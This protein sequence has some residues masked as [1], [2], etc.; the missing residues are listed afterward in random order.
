MNNTLDYFDAL[1]QINT[2]QSAK[3]SYTKK[4]STESDEIY[5]KYDDLKRELIKKCNE[6]KAVVEKKKETF[7]K[8][9]NSKS[10][11]YR[12]IVRNTKDMFKLFEILLSEPSEIVFENWGDRDPVNIIHIPVDNGYIK[13]YIYITPNKKPKNRFSLHLRIKSIFRFKFEEFN[14]NNVLKAL[15]TEKEL[16]TWYERNKN[17]LKWKYPCEPPPGIGLKWESGLSDTLTSHTCLEQ[18]YE[19][20]KTLWKD[21]KWQ[22]A[23][24]LHKKD[25]Y[26]NHYSNGVDTDEY[27]DICLLLETEKKTD[28]PLL[29]GQIKSSIGLKELERRFKE[30]G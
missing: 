17:E 13:V 22:R 20:T 15:P 28:L 29:I 27:H 24:W 2:L 10:E 4:C 23:Y 3:E 14:I 11:P 21:K 1:K 12:Q 30:K 19:E 9:N 8:E 7:E 5:W 16:R 26:E 18:K 25:Y 6:E